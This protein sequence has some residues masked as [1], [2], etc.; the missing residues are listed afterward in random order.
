MATINVSTPLAL[1]V[2]SLS[3]SGNVTFGAPVALADGEDRA[4]FLVR[5]RQAVVDLRE[6]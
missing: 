3:T 5:A 6:R 1:T 4:S 2:G